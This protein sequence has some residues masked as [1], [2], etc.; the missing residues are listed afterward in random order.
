MAFNLGSGLTSSLGNIRTPDPVN[1]SGTSKKF[2]SSIDES[3]LANSQNAAGAIRDMAQAQ[4]EISTASATEAL[5]AIGGAFGGIQDTT[6]PI[7]LPT[8]TIADGI[9][10]AA[11][12]LSV[13]RKVEKA[14]T[15]L[16]ETTIY[17]AYVVVFDTIKSIAQSGN[18][19]YELALTPQQQAELRPLLQ[20]YGYTV[21]NVYISSLSGFASRERFI[22]N[23][24]VSIRW[25][26]S[27]YSTSG[28]LY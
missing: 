8:P 27:G 9:P 23:N 14:A 16:K 2:F 18:Y 12:M 20:K 28:G 7:N 10:T 1:L 25:G 3:I 21:D 19:S 13:A 15:D 4:P 22:D 26:T 6:T 5:A 17:N 11:T 24:K